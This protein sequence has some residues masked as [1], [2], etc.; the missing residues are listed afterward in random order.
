MV[1]YVEKK[2]LSSYRFTKSYHFYQQHGQKE[3]VRNRY[4]WVVSIDFITKYIDNKRVQNKSVWVING[5][6]FGQWEHGDQ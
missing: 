3:Y 4:L 5:R 6:R 1:G 2:L